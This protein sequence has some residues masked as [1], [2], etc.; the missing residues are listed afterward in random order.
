MQRP[1]ECFLVFF[2]LRSALTPAARLCKIGSNFYVT[3][4]FYVCF[5]PRDRKLRR[6]AR[7]DGR[8]GHRRG[9]A[10]AAAHQGRARHGQ[11]H[12]GAGRRRRA[13]QEAHHLEREIHH[14]GA[15]RS[16]RLRRR[17]ASLRQPVRLRR[18]GRHRKIHQARQARRGILLRRAGGAAHRRGG[19]GR[20]GISER[21]PLGAGQDGVLHSR[22]EGDGQGEAAPHRHHHVQRGKGAA[23]RL[24]APLHLPLHRLPHAGADG[25]DHPRPL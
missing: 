2:L 10:K 4:Y 16:V 22:D 25:E 12:A 19:Q 18:R 21:P 6:L 8:G 15:G 11:D 24:P 14:Q 17:P 20:P 3:R 9:A 13:G 23:R 5:L 7:A 1:F